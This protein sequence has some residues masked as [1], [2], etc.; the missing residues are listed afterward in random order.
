M[1]D[2][3]RESGWRVGHVD[4]QVLADE[5]IREELA[6]VLRIVWEAGLDRLIE[7]SAAATGEAW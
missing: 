7:A 1:Q 4:Q 6:G 5:L 3:I 2:Q